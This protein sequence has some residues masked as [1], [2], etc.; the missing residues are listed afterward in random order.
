[1]SNQ[2]RW[3]NP[4]T[5]LPA[6]TEGE[7][8]SA[9]FQEGESF[10]NPNFGTMTVISK[11]GNSYEIE[12]DR[13]GVTAL[14]ED[15]SK[16]SDD[17]EEKSENESES[18][19]K[20]A[21]PFEDNPIYIKTDKENYKRGEVIQVFACLEDKAATKGVNINVYDLQG[22]KIS[23]K[24]MVPNLDNTVSAEFLIDEKFATN[25]TYTIEV[26][27]AGLYSNTKT[28]VVPEF[29]VVSILVLGSSIGG[30]ILLLR[31]RFSNLAKLD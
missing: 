3:I 20:C 18:I 19:E 17:L 28:V 23:S 27:S 15:P 22:K 21:S 6:V 7:A 25:S 13:T 1:M 30:I 10:S 4:V 31:S 29:G 8:G 24:T 16:T 26:D 2:L 5:Q 9:A 11:I 14:V 12:I